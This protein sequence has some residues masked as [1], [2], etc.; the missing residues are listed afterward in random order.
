VDSRERWQ[1]LQSSFRDARAAL[2]AGDRALAFEAVQRAL[3]IDPNFLAAQV[4]RDRLLAAPERAP[5]HCAAPAEE[6][7][8]ETASGMAEGLAR[9]E[10]RAKRRRVQR[11]LEAAREAISA[12]RL[13]QA[14]AAVEE[15]R[16]LSPG[17]PELAELTRAIEQGRSRR[18][19]GRLG[20]AA[21]V[22]TGVIL[23]A[24]PLQDEPAPRADATREPLDVS[25]SISTPPSPPPPEAPA[26]TVSAV[27]LPTPPPPDRGTTP[28]VPPSTVE[29]A[30]RTLAD[31][32][33]PAPPVAASET[34]A[35]LTAPADEIEDDAGI[36]VLPPAVPAIDPEI[37]GQTIAVGGQSVAI[38][39][40]FLAIDE[41]LVLKALQQY[42]WAYEDLDAASAVAVWPTVE[43]NALARAF[44][45]LASQALT[46][47]DC[48][49]RTNGQVAT[50]TCAGTTRYVPKVGSR[51]P[52]VEP[53]RWSFSLRKRED[54]WQIENARAER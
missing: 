9:F 44:D 18:A 45:G 25:T 13:A 27:E 47:H 36:A 15:L 8:A 3:A 46:F 11:R 48:S 12:S 22:F 32:G 19:G 10:E 50:A 54:A 14:S 17:L 1:A 31:A 20:L 29:A 38:D 5:S 52:R 23:L 30:G 26:P 28:P 41:E 53:R 6:R 51:E 34:R 33:P 49:V 21:A 40:Q 4:F 43:R 16:E 7:S 35:P 24:S 42:R 39:E 2:A 37:D